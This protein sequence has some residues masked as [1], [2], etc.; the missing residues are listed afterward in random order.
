MK[1]PVPLSISVPVRVCGAG[2]SGSDVSSSSSSNLEQPEGAKF[3]VEVKY[4][5]PDTQVEDMTQESIRDITGPTTSMKVLECEPPC[6]DGPPDIADRRNSTSKQSLKYDAEAC[7]SKVLLDP[8]EST[9]GSKDAVKH[10]SSASALVSS[11]TWVK[12]GRV[13]LTISDRDDIAGGFQ[14]THYSTVIV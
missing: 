2:T 5:L 9:S 14:L 12:F 1:R 7:L 10:Q 4:T 11:S 6:Q 3:T 13:S 8:V